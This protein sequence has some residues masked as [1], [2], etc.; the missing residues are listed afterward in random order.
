MNAQ[1]KW[2]ALVPQLPKGRHTFSFK[3]A[4][5]TGLAT[6]GGGGGTDVLDILKF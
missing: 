2:R 4:S 3:S 1:A 6:A 5:L